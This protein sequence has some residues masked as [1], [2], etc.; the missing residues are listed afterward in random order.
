M[1]LLALLTKRRVRARSV[2]A[3]RELRLG[4]TV[5]AEEE[6]IAAEPVSW[7]A[8]GRPWCARKN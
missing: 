4:D 2:A 7:R 1:C 6:T 8:A 3:V 5:V